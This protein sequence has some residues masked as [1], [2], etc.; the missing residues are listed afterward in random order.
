M[1]VLVLGPD[2][3]FGFG[4]GRAGIPSAGVDRPRFQLSFESGRP[5]RP[6]HQFVA[7]ETVPLVDQAAN[8]F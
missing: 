6:T 7:F 5:G 4:P 1:A 3:C 8:T 2:G